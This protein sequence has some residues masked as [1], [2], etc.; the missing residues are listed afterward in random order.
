MLNVKGNFEPWLKAE[1][2]TAIYAD[3]NVYHYIQQVLWLDAYTRVWTIH[4]LIDK[5]IDKTE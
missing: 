3:S 1:G 5:E 4:D 2:S